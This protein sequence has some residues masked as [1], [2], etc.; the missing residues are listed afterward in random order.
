MYGKV[1]ELYIYMYV[2]FF[3]L[4]SHLDCYMILIRN[5]AHFFLVMRAFKI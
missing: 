5:S 3:K 1:I 4:F 2:F